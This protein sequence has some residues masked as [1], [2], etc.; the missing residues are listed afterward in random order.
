MFINRNKQQDCWSRLNASRAAQNS[1]VGRMFVTSALDHN[2]STKN[3]SKSSKV[4]KD[5]DCS[6]VSNTNFSEMLL[7][8]GRRPGP[9]KVGQGGLKVLYLWHHSQ[10]ICNPQAKH[11]FW[12]QTR[13]LTTSFELL[14]GSAVLIGPERFSCKAMC[15]PVVLAQEFLISAGRQSVN[16]WQHFLST[17]F[18]KVAVCKHCKQEMSYCWK[19]RKVVEMIQNLHQKLVP[20]ITILMVIPAHFKHGMCWLQTL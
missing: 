3:P 20:L 5:L 10:K 16:V 1:F 15:D 8:N 12:V 9:G 17:S 6:L 14:T 18:D 19:H 13:R 11:F 2:F 4:S 7:S